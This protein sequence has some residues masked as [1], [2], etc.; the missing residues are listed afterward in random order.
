MYGRLAGKV[1]VLR[2]LLKLMRRRDFSLEFAM[3]SLHTVPSFFLS[4]E[5]IAGNF[6]P[7][8]KH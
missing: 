6:L 2:I 3:L 5:K 1:R 4:T 8:V 7:E